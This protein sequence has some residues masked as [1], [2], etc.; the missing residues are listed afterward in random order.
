LHLSNSS[1]KSVNWWCIGRGFKDKL[2][3]RN[4]VMKYLPKLKPS[5]PFFLQVLWI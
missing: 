3:M 4:K 1:S 5:W 2:Q